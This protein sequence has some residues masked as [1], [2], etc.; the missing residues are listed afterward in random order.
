MAIID[1]QIGDKE[2]EVIAADNGVMVHQTSADKQL[3]FCLSDEEVLKLA[4]FAKDLEK[5]FG[6]PQDMEWAV[7]ADLQYPNNIFLLQTR[8]IKGI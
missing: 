3:T 7:S 6:V 2:K 8:P 5:H 4:E 1:R